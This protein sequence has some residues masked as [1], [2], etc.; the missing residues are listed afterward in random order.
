MYYFIFCYVEIF[1]VWQ[2][3]Y[4]TIWEN[5]NRFIGNETNEYLRKILTTETKV[6]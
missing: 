3:N 4:L 6:P 1:L 2:Q 5:R